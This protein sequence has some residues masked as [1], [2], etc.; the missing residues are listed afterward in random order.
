[1]GL[2]ASLFSLK[3]QE[4]PAPPSEIVALMGSAKYG[5]GI[6]MTEF[7]QP[8]LEV[9]CGK[10]MSRGVNRFETARLIPEE[11]NPRDKFAVRVEIRGRPVG[12]LKVEHAIRFRQQLLERGTPKANGE[13]PA[14]ITGGWVSSD[15]RRGDYEIWLDLP[16]AYQ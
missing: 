4:P 3:P 10:R 9:I 8:A 6:T 16:S 14:L 5:R 13:C 15:G 2:F 1:M 11:K 12:Y 7:Y